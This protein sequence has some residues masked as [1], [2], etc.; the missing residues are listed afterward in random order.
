MRVSDAGHR[1]PCNVYRRGRALLDGNPVPPTQPRQQIAN[2]SSSSAVSAANAG[3]A[4]Y[5]AQDHRDTVLA[6]APDHRTG[7][8][9]HALDLPSRLAKA[10][11][12]LVDADTAGM[13]EAQDVH[14]PEGRRQHHRDD[15]RKH[16]QAA[17][18]L[19]RQEMGAPALDR[20]SCRPTALL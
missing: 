6:A 12:R 8:R 1:Q 4:G 3:G 18:H 20:R 2:C 15:A 10:L 7:S 16:Q 11:M 14:H 13:Q 9:G 19:G 5:C 17:A